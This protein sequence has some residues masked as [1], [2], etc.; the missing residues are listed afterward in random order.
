MTFLCAL[1]FKK[2]VRTDI[3]VAAGETRRLIIHDFKPRRGDIAYPNVAPNGASILRGS[4]LRW[5]LPA[6][7][8]RLIELN[9]ITQGQ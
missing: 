1:R 2:S 9:E 5:V 3:L 7:N 6:A 8:P 4:F